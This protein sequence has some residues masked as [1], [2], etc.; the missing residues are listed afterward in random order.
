MQ[1]VYEYN[2]REVKPQV[3]N[4]LLFGLLW[5][6]QRKHTSVDR[7]KQVKTDENVNDRKI[8]LAM[9]LNEIIDIDPFVPITVKI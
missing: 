6:G 4:G 1:W 2:Q 3:E 7:E 8:D 5:E 9:F